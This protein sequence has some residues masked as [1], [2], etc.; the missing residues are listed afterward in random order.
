[1]VN[2]DMVLLASAGFCRVC[3]EENLTV[4][5]EVKMFLAVVLQCL[6]IENNAICMGMRNLF[7]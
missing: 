3:L 4:A 1:M 7:I 2:L 5:Q 6:F